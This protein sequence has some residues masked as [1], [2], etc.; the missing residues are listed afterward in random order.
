MG[1]V[2]RKQ[3]MPHAIFIGAKLKK[4]L[5]ED[6]NLTQ[7]NLSWAHAEEIMVSNSNLTGA[8]MTAIFAPRAQFIHKTKLI[9]AKMSGGRFP[10]AHFIEVLAKKVKLFGVWMPNARILDSHFDKAILVATLFENALFENT[11]L[12]EADARNGIFSNAQ[13]MGGDLS[14]ID[15]SWANFRGVIMKGN[16]LCRKAVLKEANCCDADLRGAKELNTAF[17]GERNLHL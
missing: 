17:L 11:T 5:I 7:G 10:N 4:V 6:T 9:K 12:R 15:A 16:V 3:E 2:F 1:Q 14:Y 13:F 8:T